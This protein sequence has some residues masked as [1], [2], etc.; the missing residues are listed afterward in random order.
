M[1]LIHAS[2]RRLLELV[3]GVLFYASLMAGKVTVQREICGLA[4]LCA[5]SI[6]SLKEKS[7]RRTR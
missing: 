5:A 6:S 1:N 7:A 4:D 2:G 3:N